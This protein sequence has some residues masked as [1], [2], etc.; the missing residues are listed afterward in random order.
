MQLVIFDSAVCDY[1]MKLDQGIV[2]LAKQ[3]G[4]QFLGCSVACQSTCRT[5]LIFR[6]EPSDEL[7]H[8][9]CACS[10][11]YGSPEIIIRNHRLPNCASAVVRRGQEWP[12]PPCLSRFVKA[13]LDV[14]RVLP[15]L[16][17]FDGHG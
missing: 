1:F 12:G 2:F 5:P 17:G 14:M 10:M 7:H 8:F 11:G 6:S 13:V 4:T 9:V 16:L 3:L 15:Q